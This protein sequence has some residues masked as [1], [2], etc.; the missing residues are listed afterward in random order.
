MILMVMMMMIKNLLAAKPI[1]HRLPVKSLLELLLSGAGSRQDGH[2][3]HHHPYGHYHDEHCGHGHGYDH[4]NDDDNDH[5]YDECDDHDDD[6]CDDHDTDDCDHDDD[7]D[8]EDDHHNNDNTI[9][10][11]R[12]RSLPWW[13]C[14][15]SFCLWRSCW[16]SRRFYL[17]F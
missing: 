7:D 4:N 12:L 15:R 14:W 8:D 2:H 1:S 16:R 10:E 13:G 11:S 17:P 3:C 9:R 5:I 6:D